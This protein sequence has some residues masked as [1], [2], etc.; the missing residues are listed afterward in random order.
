MNI[1]RHL[2]TFH[3]K[4]TSYINLGGKFPDKY[5]R[6]NQYLLLLYNYDINAILVYPFKTRQAGE[7]TKVWTT[8]HHKLTHNGHITKHYI[9]HNECRV[10][11]KKVLS[12]SDLTYELTPSSI[13]RRNI[14]EKRISNL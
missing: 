9:I 7:L 2:Y 3:Q 5:S 12:K 8:L 10:D 13:Y 14:T 1:Y 4:E 11:F 6:G